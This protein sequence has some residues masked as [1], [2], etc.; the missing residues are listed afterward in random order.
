M[1][2]VMNMDLVFSL[3]Q[4]IGEEISDYSDE[5]LQG[6]TEDP[7][8]VGECARAELEAR[9]YVEEDEDKDE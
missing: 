7:G 4:T 2:M 6:L 9:S 3:S 5:Q 8:I 1:V